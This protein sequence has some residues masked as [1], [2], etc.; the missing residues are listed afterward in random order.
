[1]AELPDLDADA[2]RVALVAL[3]EDGELDV[4][5]HVARVGGHRVRAV[6]E[7]RGGGVVSG[8]AYAR[9]VLEWVGDIDV[10]WQCREGERLDAGAVL[11]ELLGP[12]GSLLRAERPMLNLL[13]R[14]CGIAT[15]T[16]AFVE[17]VRETRCRILHTRKTAPGLRWFDVRAVMAGG[18][19]VHRVNLASAALIKD[20]HWRVMR[21]AGVELEPA[22][23]A[24]RDRGIPCYVEVESVAQVERAVSAGATRLLIDNQLPE[25][26]RKWGRLARGFAPGIEIEAS[27]GITLDN[28]RAYAEAGA[29]FVSVG[30]LTHSAPAADVSMELVEER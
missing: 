17:A 2:R 6:I 3:E 5:T 1:M 24:A 25:T 19:G 23:R 26:V 4:T 29:D 20:N 16:R 8:V 18:G 28:V 9:A 27:G 11:A 12:A 30:A 21:A 14:A 22:I 13:G 7:Y 10:E 15:L